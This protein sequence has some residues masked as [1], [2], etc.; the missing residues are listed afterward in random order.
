M[1]RIILALAFGLCSMT[2]QAD[3]FPY[4]TGGGYVFED[5]EATS[6]FC[7]SITWLAD[8][9]ITLGCAAIDNSNTRRLYCPNDYV[10]RNQIAA[11][12][13]RLG[14]SLFPTNCANKS[15]MRWNATT[16]AWECHHNNND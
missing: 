13:N 10:D 1:K 4:C 8:R 11:F 7:P 12:L 14:N 3:P 2:A 6:E 16:Q 15:F 9:G 5:V